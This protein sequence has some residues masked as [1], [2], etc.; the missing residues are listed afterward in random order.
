MSDLENDIQQADPDKLADIIEAGLASTEAGGLQSPR[1]QPSEQFV[2]LP[3]E[4]LLRH[5]SLK[6]L[7]RVD[8]FDPA[9]R[10][11]WVIL[12]PSGTHA[13]HVVAYD[14]LGV[15]ARAPSGMAGAISLRPGEW[16][17]L[18][19]ERTADG[20]ARFQAAVVAEEPEWGTE[21]ENGIGFGNVVDYVNGNAL[22]VKAIAAQLQ[23]RFIKPWDVPAEFALAARHAGTSDS[24]DNALHSEQA[25]HSKLSDMAMRADLAAKAEIG[26][27][28]TAAMQ[29]LIAGNVYLLKQGGDSALEFLAEEPVAVRVFVADCPLAAGATDSELL[30]QIARR[31]CL[32]HM[33]LRP[34][35]G[36]AAGSPPGLWVI[37]LDGATNHL[38]VENLHEHNVVGVARLSDG[39]LVDVVKLS[40]EP[41]P[42]TS[43]DR[44]LVRVVNLAA[45]L[46]VVIAAWKSDPI[47]PVLSPGRKVG[48]GRY[49]LLRLLGIGGMGVVWLAEDDRLEERVALKFLLRIFAPI[50]P[51][52]KICV[53][54]HSG[55]GNYLIPTLSAFMICMQPTGSLPLFPWSTLTA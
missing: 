12:E 24:A 4:E 9:G 30:A 3:W 38:R 51:R 37:Y 31:D 53:A 10:T 40:E 49:T 1:D 19:I 25:E 16:G 8:G 21:T 36:L 46:K 29:K 20:L 35:A 43:A 50:L 5:L 32:M 55:A 33:R 6:E 14:Y 13:V 54:R 47:L 7:L 2:S 18:R 45:D 39:R 34:A 26:V 22:V 44:S 48:A 17:E 23:W 41:T 52:W 11:F 15:T 42:D 27:S 28:Q